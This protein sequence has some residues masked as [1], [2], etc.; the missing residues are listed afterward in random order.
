MAR[1]K[2]FGSGGDKPTEEISFSLYGESFSCRPAVPGK[3]LLD[4]VAKSSDDENPGKAAGVVNDFFNVVLTPESFER[5]DKL[6]SDPERIVQVDTLAEIVSWL[7]EQYSDR[8]TTR[9]EAS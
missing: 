1:F 5:F 8:P 3:V 4:L 9:P 2:D 6:T 7:V